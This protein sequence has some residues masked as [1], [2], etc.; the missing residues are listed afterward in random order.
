MSKEI[1]LQRSELV[2][3]TR[4]IYWNNKDWDNLKEWVKSQ[5]EKAQQP[6]NQ[7][8]GWYQSFIKIYD[9]IKDMSWDDAVREYENW[10]NSDEDQLYWEDTYKYYDGTSHTYK[11]YFGDWFLECMREDVYDADIES[12]D[13]ADD[14]DEDIEILDAEDKD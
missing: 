9:V 10:D 5:A 2:W 7:E 12:E 8:S 4:C 14:Y 11:Q 13:Y 3:Q 1:R 6:E